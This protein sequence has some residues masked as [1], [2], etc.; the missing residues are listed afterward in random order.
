MFLPCRLGILLLNLTN[1]F[2]DKHLETAYQRYSQR[3]RQKSLVILNIINIFLKIVIL[4]AYFIA[5]AQNGPEAMSPFNSIDSSYCF[6]LSTNFFFCEAYSFDRFKVSFFCHTD[7]SN[8]TAQAVK[9]FYSGAESTHHHRQNK[10]LRALYSLPWIFANCLLIILITCWKRFANDYLY[11]GAL[12]T[13]IICS[14]EGKLYFFLS[15]RI[16]I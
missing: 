9:D 15:M 7:H 11:V 1:Q 6:N 12:I 16:M 10:L 4:I 13:W 8:Q 5:E 14:I 2:K 3:Q